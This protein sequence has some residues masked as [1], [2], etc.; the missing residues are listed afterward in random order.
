MMTQIKKKVVLEDDGS[1]IWKM[2][3]YFEIVCFHFCYFKEPLTHATAVSCFS[4]LIT[5]KIETF[6]HVRLWLFVFEC[7]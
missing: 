2:I 5:L 4:F 3:C 7:K 6:I 1:I